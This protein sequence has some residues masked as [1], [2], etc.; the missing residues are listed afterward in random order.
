MTGLNPPE[1]TRHYS[2]AT[3]RTYRLLGPLAGGETGANL[4][5]GADGE[6]RV[7][8]LESTPSPTGDRIP[9]VT[10]SRS[11]TISISG[12]SHGI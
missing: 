2:T 6:R 8:K 4:I 12:C 11:V 3:S 1:A 10:R 5:E 7:L 9:I